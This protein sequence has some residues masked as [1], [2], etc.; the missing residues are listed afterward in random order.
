MKIQPIN[1]KVVVRPDAQADQ[2]AGGLMLPIG[3]QE[4]QQAGT[5]VAA[6]P[7]RTHETTGLFKPCAVKEGDR[8][9]YAK[10]SGVE[11]ELNGAKVLMLDESDVLAILTEE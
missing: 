2:T 8:V 9:L 10:Y 5:V 6:G 4:R 3:A 7:G 1:D 11:F